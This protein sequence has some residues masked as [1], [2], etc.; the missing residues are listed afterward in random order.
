MVLLNCK[1]TL[2]SG[3]PELLVPL[4]EQGGKKRLLYQVEWPV[5]IT[6][7][8]SGCCYTIEVRKS[9]SR[10]QEIPYLGHLPVLLCLFIRVNG[11]LPQPSQAGLMLTHSLQEQRSGPPPQAKNHGQQKCLLKAKERR[12]EVINTSFRKKRW[13]RSISDSLCCK[14]IC[15][16][17][18]IK[19][20]CFLSL[21]PYY[22]KVMNNS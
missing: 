15:V 19:Y 13:N 14:Y 4:N 5:P 8:K 1:L 12:K 2:P 16:C 21:A 20:F 3:H 22:H 7:G 6:K 18:Y 10:L 11:K 17:T 9:V